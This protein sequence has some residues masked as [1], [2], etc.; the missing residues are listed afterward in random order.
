MQILHADAH[1][2]PAFLVDTHK[3]LYFVNFTHT[4][5]I[6]TVHWPNY[7]NPSPALMIISVVGI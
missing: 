4:Y 5:K 1:L 7:P 2:G 3:L 6:K